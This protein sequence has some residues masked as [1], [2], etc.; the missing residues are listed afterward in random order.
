MALLTDDILEKLQHLLVS[1][2]LIEKSVLDDAHARAKQAEKPLFSLLTE[3]NILDTELLTHA[4]A[5]VSGMPRRRHRASNPQTL[6]ARI[7][8][9]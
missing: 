3:E 5:Q 2:G 8:C 1:E 6:S 9:F 7:D 4:V